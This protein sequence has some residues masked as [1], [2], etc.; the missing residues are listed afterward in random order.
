MFKFIFNILGFNISNPLLEKIVST[1]SYDR[2]ERTVTIYSFHGDEK[3]ITFKDKETNFTISFCEKKFETDGNHISSGYT[4]YF[5]SENSF[6]KKELK[7]LFKLINKKWHND[8]LVTL[9]NEQ[10]EI[11]KKQYV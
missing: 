3:T 8:I 9:N 5:S 10:K 1:L 11:L 2:W 7:Y 6:T 4:K